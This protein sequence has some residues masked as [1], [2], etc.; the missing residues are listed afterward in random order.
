MYENERK[1]R[2]P[3]MSAGY[4]W[5]RKSL[6]YGAKHN[7]ETVFWNRNGREIA[8]YWMEIMPL[9]DVKMGH[10]KDLFALIVC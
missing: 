2:L 4:V 5:C 7:K 1:K 3:L 10:K 6:C 9:L 8:S